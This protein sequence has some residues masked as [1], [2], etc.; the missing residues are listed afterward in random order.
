MDET[1]NS[2][3]IRRYQAALEHMETL[4]EQRYGAAYALASLLHDAVARGPGDSLC[5]MDTALAMALSTELHRLNGE[6]ASAVDALN[7]AAS[8]AG[9][10]PVSFVKPGG[11]TQDPA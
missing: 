9:R 1:G 11:E 3:A 2:D 8:A 10:P 7:A 5:E 4:R 6:L